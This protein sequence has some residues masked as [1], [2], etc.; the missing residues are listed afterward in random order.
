MDPSTTT[1]ATPASGHAQ[2]PQ[3]LRLTILLSPTKENSAALN[4]IAAFA[5]AKL[6]VAG[7]YRSIKASIEMIHAMKTYGAAPTLPK[8]NSSRTKD[9]DEKEKEGK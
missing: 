3:L 8:P 5:E 6:A 7:G 4:E 1:S 2:K 9:E